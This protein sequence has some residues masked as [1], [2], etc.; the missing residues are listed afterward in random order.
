MVPE[1]GVSLIRT[2]RA[3]PG[4]RDAIVVVLTTQTSASLRQHALEAGADVYLVKPCGV[5]HLGEVMTMASD[6]RAR[7]IAPDICG[8]KPPL[9]RLRQAVRRSRAIR[10]RLAADVPANPVPPEGLH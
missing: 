3:E 8:A 5:L 9:S 10:E 2:L 6:H 4:C 7:L 1:G